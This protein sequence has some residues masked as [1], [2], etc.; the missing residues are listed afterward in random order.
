MRDFTML[1]INVLHKKQP[2][3]TVSIK[4][5]RVDTFMSGGPGGQHKNATQSAVRITHT[6]SGATGQGVDS[7]DQPKNK[8]A[9]FSKMV[10]SETFRKWLRVE[11]AR[12]V[13]SIGE[14][15]TTERAIHQRG[16]GYVRTYHFKRNEVVD[17]R[18]G[19]H[20][21]LDPVLDGSGLGEVMT[22]LLIHYAPLSPQPSKL[23]KG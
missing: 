14:V 4:D 11:V 20:Y 12:R 22:D 13:G 17:H 6:A 15:T 23:V 1:Q 10:N 2:L 9:A 21:E 5:C 16:G 18:T 3:F 7:R 8:A 19:K